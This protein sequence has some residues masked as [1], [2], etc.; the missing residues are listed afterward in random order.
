MDCRQE[1]IW[2]PDT[3][4]PSHTEMHNFRRKHGAWMARTHIHLWMRL[5]GQSPASVPTTRISAAKFSNKEAGRDPG[6][7]MEDS[8][9][10]IH[11]SIQ[12][13]PDEGG[14]PSVTVRSTLRKHSTVEGATMAGDGRL[15]D[16][17]DSAA[18]VNERSKS[19]SNKELLWAVALVILV[20]PVALV[21]AVAAI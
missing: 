15:D 12:M 1:A 3:K 21:A 19:P 16:W 20:I 10:A 4:P 7:P 6:Q 13:A 14:G 18:R 9:Y 5:E 11:P 2:L 17:Y 8:P